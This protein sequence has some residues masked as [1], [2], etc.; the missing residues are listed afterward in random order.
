MSYIIEFSDEFE[1]SM[2]KLKKRNNVVFDQIQRKLIQ[3]IANPEHYKP[4]RNEL[5]GYRRINFGSFVLIYTIKLETI[6]V[7]SLDHHDKAC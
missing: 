5:A 4:L 6:R 2:K 1:R 7:V 3:I